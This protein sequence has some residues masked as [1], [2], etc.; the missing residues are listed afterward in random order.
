MQ[1]K[2]FLKL[3]E[4]P[5]GKEEFRKYIIENL[6]YPETAVREKVAGTVHLAADISDNGEVLDVQVVKGIG[7]GCDEE[8]VRLIRGC[9]FGGVKNKGVRLKTRKKFRI[10]FDL[11]QQQDNVQQQIVYNFK[12]ERKEISSDHSA[13][14]HPQPAT[15]YGYTI[16]FGGET[17]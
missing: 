9:H 17:P 3:P 6:K 12:T 2:R 14:S 11:P 4:Y 5:G 15:T 16:N 10:R 8:A 13:D 1:K 7:Y